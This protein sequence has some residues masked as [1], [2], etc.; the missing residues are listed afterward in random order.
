MA[1]K[2]SEDHSDYSNCFDHDAFALVEEEVMTHVFGFTLQQQFEREIYLAEDRPGNIMEAIKSTAKQMVGIFGYHAKNG[3]HRLVIISMAE[4]LSMPAV[5]AITV[6]LRSF[7]QQGDNTADD[8]L[9]T[10]KTLHQL[11][12]TIEPMQDAIQP[13]STLHGNQGQLVYELL[14]SAQHL[15]LTAQAI[16]K[17]DP[18]YAKEKFDIAQTHLGWTQQ[19]SQQSYP[20]IFPAPAVES[21]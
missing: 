11:H 4:Q 16:L 8:Y 9:N 5:E 13:A 17:D 6:F 10:I 21:V 2:H 7:R 3:Y 20:D 12:S 19:L 15:I 14:T 1:T 18:R